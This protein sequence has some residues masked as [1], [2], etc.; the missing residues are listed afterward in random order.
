M[1]AVARL[2]TAFMP[3]AKIWSKM[4]ENHIMLVNQCR[5]NLKSPQG[6]KLTPGGWAIKYN[7][8]WRIE[9]M[10]NYPKPWIE[11]RGIT[12]GHKVKAEIAKS[13][14][15]RPFQTAIFPLIYGKGFD[16]G[17]ELVEMGL[18]FG[19]ITKG[20]AWFEVPGSDKKFQGEL[21]T[22]EF[23]RENPK[24][25]EQIKAEIRKLFK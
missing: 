16:V 20:G 18:Q 21:D 9:L 24:V 2:F 23:I 1:A 4:N 7:C 14:Y 19:I 8:D 12:V 15:G 17:L 6:G 10:L 13:R 3:K 5:D 25:Q 11:N 22:A